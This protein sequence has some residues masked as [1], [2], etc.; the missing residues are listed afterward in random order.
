MGGSVLSAQTF[1][2]QPSV[3]SL[4]PSSGFAGQSIT[5]SGTGFFGVT[6]VKFN[7]VAGTFGTVAADGSSLHVVIP[8][9][10]TTGTVTVTTSGGTGA[11]STT[12]VVLPHVTTFSPASGVAGANVTI[13]GTG[14]S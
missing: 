3:T 10:A 7:G 13:G 4:S 5:V 2:L 9:G 1:G 8:A 11:S 14:F 12:F 6:S